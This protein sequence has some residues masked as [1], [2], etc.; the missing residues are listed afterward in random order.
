MQEL[1]HSAPALSDRPTPPSSDHR[2]RLLETELQQQ[3]QLIVGTQKENE[4]LFLQVK[5][6][7]V[8]V[9]TFLHR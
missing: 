4:K 2:V 5:H 3:E 8:S 1:E 9:T 6:L 7:K